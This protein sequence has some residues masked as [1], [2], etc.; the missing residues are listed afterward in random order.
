[1]MV[2]PQRISVFERV[3]TKE[4]VERIYQADKDVISLTSQW[5]LAILNGD[6]V[7]AA[8]VRR[9]SNKIKR[10]IRNKYNIIL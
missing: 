3:R 6:Q 4:D 9:E 2:N 8:R 5:F 10:D 7:V 1:M